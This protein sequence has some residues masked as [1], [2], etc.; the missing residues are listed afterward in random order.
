[1]RTDGTTET[2]TSDKFTFTTGNAILQI[3]NV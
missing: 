2:L 3:S 1:M